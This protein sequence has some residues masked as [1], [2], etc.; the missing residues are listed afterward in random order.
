MILIGIGHKR[1]VGKDTC[2]KYL[3]E[4]YGFFKIAF[5]D[6]LKETGRVLFGFSDEQLY[7]DLKDI[8]DPD[9]G[10]TPRQALHWMGDSLRYGFGTAAVASGAWPKADQGLFLVRVAKHAITLAQKAGHDRIILSDVRHPEEFEM[11]RRMGG[12]MV[13]VVREDVPQLEGEIH[14]HATE[15]GL[16]TVPDEAW[17]LVVPNHGGN[18]TEYQGYLDRLMAGLQ[19][20]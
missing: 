15:A 10:F 6:R 17:D 11:V 5:A 3:V 14:S 12:Q 20:G 4:N 13:K 8:V 9:W 18:T 19:V 2:A 16:N 1:R 7:G